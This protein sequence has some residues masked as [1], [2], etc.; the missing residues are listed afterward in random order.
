MMAS[1]FENNNLSYFRIHLG[2]VCQTRF[3]P[4]LKSHL[5]NIYDHDGLEGS[6][7]GN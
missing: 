1:M 6:H 4:L 2:Y 7:L 3:M 5:F